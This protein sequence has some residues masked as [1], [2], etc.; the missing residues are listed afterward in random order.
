MWTFFLA[1]QTTAP[2]LF[3]CTPKNEQPM[4]RLHQATATV[5][6][7]HTIQLQRRVLC[8]FYM[9]QGFTWEVS[10]VIAP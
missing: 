5:L 6:R 1:E 3:P 4:Q 10:W 2:R 7:T 8:A 9:S